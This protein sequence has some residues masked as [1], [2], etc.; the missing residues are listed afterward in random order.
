[1]LVFVRYAYLL[2]IALFVLQCTNAPI[3]EKISVS[4]LAIIPLPDSM[5]VSGALSDL[6]ELRIAHGEFWNIHQSWLKTFPLKVSFDGHEPNTILETDESLEQYQ[7]E[8][9]ISADKLHIRAKT[10]SDVRNGFISLQ[11]LMEQYGGRLP[12][13][14]ILDQ[15]EFDYRGMHLDVGRHMF[16]TKDIKQ[17]IDYL[18][19]YKFNRF[20]WHL[21]E[22]QGWRIEIPSYP[23]LQEISAYRKE[24]LIGH[25]NDQP[26]QFDRTRYGGYY[27]QEEIKDVV[28]YASARG[29]EIIP[30]IEMPGHAQAAIAAYPEFGCTGD[31]IDVATKWGVFEDVFCPNPETFKFLKAVIDDVTD[32][33]PSSYIH[34]GGDECPKDQ[35]KASQFCQALIKE[36]GIKDEYELQSYFIGVMADYIQSKGRSIIGWDEILEGGLH[37]SATVMSWRGTDGAIAAAKEG[38]RAIMT[39]GSHCYFDHYQSSHPDEPLAIGGLTT[40]KDVYQFNPIPKELNEEEAE[41]IWGVQGNVWTEYMQD[42]DQVSYMALARM[43]ALSEVQWNKVDNRDYE[44]YMSRYSY[45]VEYWRSRNV[46]IASH[47]F[48]LELAIQGSPSG[49][50]VTT[51]SADQH[52]KT[53]VTYPNGITE[54]VEEKIFL[55][56]RGEYSFYA[57]KDGQKGRKSSIFY[58]P[59]LGNKALLK[60]ENNPSASYAGSGSDALINGILGSEEKYGGTEWLGFS[61]EDMVATISFPKETVLNQITVQFYKGEGQWIYLPNSI[62]ILTS[63]DG[64][65]F[66]KLKAIDDIAAFGKLANVTIPVETTTQFVKIHAKRHGIIEPGKQGAGHEA[67]LFVGEIIVE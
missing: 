21:T 62:E 63:D 32:L 52:V 38:H 9:E 12:I 16:A 51:K 46:N 3:D 40:L 66:N 11:Q 37:P 31:T 18:T 54:P 64:V 14:K 20:H 58:N 56:D 53:F 59:H 15:A 23:K 17:Y 33:F 19:Y 44:K 43:T 2:F 39:P 1:M 7:Y 6:T 25:Y 24:T 35:W 47:F 50:Y 10:L 34:I 60:L 26:H 65:S 29:I 22:D 55:K 27:T 36:K 61:G 67:W 49:S 5:T 41:L 8:I 13:V 28:A 45:H 57:E 48:D 4:E 30:E 42:F